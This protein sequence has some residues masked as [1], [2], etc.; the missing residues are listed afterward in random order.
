MST[1]TTYTSD[2]GRGTNLISYADGFR[3]QGTW[4]SGTS[5]SVG[6][7]VE[8]SGASYVARTAH[9]GQTPTSGSAYWQVISQAG[10]AGGPG[11][12]GASGPQGPSGP[13]GPSGN[14]ILSGASDPT[15][16]DGVDGDY[17]L[18]T[19]TNY[20]FGPKASGSWP[21]GLSL[22]GP[23]GPQGSTGPSGP[24]G[25]T[26]SQG[27]QG[28][29][30]AQGNTGPTGPTGPTGG[31]GPTGPT[32]NTGRLGRLVLLGQQVDL[33]VL[34]VILGLQARQEVLVLLVLVGLRD[35]VMVY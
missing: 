23:Q 27:P 7:L 8:Y 21:G 28:P 32:G 33:L 18:N 6:D 11:P 29:Q 4:S 34:L 30:G 1:G 14:T 2:V 13:T 17:W 9:S 31:P 12:A 5:Y 15:A 22:V 24:Q 35:K 19:T 25:P 3:Y 10:N 20:F 26:G 16:S